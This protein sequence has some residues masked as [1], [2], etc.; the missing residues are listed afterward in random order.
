MFPLSLV[1]IM[2]TMLLGIFMLFSLGCRWTLP[3]SSAGRVENGNDRKKS[4]ELREPERPSTH[5]FLLEQLQNSRTQHTDFLS[6]T[7]IKRSED[8]SEEL[9]EFSRTLNLSAASVV[10]F[11]STLASEGNLVASSELATIVTL[12]SQIAQVFIVA[13][14]NASDPEMSMDESAVQVKLK[15]SF[16]SVPRQRILACSTNSGHLAIVRQLSPV[17]HIE[18]DQALAKLLARHIRFV[19]L[20]NEDLAAAAGESLSERSGITPV[21]A[22]YMTSDGYILVDSI[23][24]LLVIDLSNVAKLPLTTVNGE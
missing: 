15:R 17:L 18:S 22:I 3:T 4:S 6:T 1:I 12:L 9:L 2:S 23:L 8:M 14:V 10:S 16:S 13:H 19:V 7:S 21:D 24:S 11:S 5:L 20:V